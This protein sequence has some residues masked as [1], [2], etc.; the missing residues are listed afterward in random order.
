MYYI[1]ERSGLVLFCI[2]H[3][4]ASSGREI[5]ITNNQVY[6]FILA[7]DGKSGYL[8]E[9]DSIEIV[10]WNEPV[11]EFRVETLPINTKET[12][13]SLTFAQ[14]G[15]QG[16]A[17]H[18]EEV[19]VIAWSGVSPDRRVERF[20]TYFASGQTIL[21]RVPLIILSVAVTPSSQIYVFGI[22]PGENNLIHEVSL[23]GAISNSFHHKELSPDV[24]DLLGNIRLISYEDSLYYAVLHTGILFQYNQSGTLLRTYKFKNIFKEGVSIREVFLG[25]DGLYLDLLRGKK[26]L[27]GDGGFS[28]TDPKREFIVL[29]NGEMRSISIDLDIKFRILGLIRNSKLIVKSTD[30]SSPGHT[31]V[32]D[33]YNPK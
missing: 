2:L 24:T 13:S 20:L 26:V 27:D 17:P 25:Q 8:L 31:S 29:K 16:V 21:L 5:P 28:M 30:V 6:Q 14:E 18:P 22:I 9:R 33:F 19:A 10:K 11:N 7:N 1:I 3:I 12:L 23:D 15:V 4:M 32:L